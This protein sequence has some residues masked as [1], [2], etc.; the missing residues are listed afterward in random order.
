MPEYWFTWV[1]IVFL[2]F[3]FLMPTMIHEQFAKILGALAYKF[4]KKRRNISKVNL[5]LCF[6]ERS[7]GELQKTVKRNFRHQA[8]SILHYGLIWWASQSVL[9]KRIRIEGE[10]NIRS[11]L[12]NQKSVIVMAAHS[13]G[14]EAAVAATSIRYPIS[15]P[16]NPI[17]N[18]LIDWFIAKGR[19]RHGARIYTRESGLRPI[20]KDVRAGCVMF[21]LPDEDLGPDRS[22]FSS[23]FGIQKATVPVLGRLAK[24]CNADVI[25]CIACYDGENEQYVIHYLPKLENFPSGDD[26]RDS[27]AMN[28]ELESLIKICSEQYFWT[29]KLFKTRPQG[30]SR[31]Y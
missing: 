15:G 23:F 8:R 12:N 24:S 27:Q 30:E 5:G 20:I 3:L 21:Y 9:N 31:L 19:A 4:N 29:M 1:L 13:Y 7:E 17:K 6:P 18:K 2:Y 14:L 16:F 11:S 26:Y 10:E 25:P 28:N 22:I